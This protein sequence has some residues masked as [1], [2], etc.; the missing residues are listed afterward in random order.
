MVEEAHSCNMGGSKLQRTVGGG[1]RSSPS[2]ERIWEHH[3]EVAMWCLGTY[4]ERH[5]NKGR[6]TRTWEQLLVEEPSLG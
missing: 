4:R 6:H 3:Q 5:G 2:R 1:R